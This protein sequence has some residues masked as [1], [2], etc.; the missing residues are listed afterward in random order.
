MQLTP[1]QNATLKA[2]LLANASTLNDQ[3]AAD[4]LNATASPTFYVY[5]TSVT[6]DEI[7]GN[8][9]NWTRVDN[10]S[11]GKARVWDW[12]FRNQKK[13]IDPSRANVRAGI[14]TVWVGTQADVDVRDAVYGHCYRAATVGEKLFASGAGTAPVNDG[15][16]SG[17]ATIDANISEPFSAQNVVDALNS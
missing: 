13:A 6:E 16:G 1:A 15:D 5:R 9:M 8:G 4:A 11:V 2:W 10:L 12:M 7:F 14:N 17:P 3:Q